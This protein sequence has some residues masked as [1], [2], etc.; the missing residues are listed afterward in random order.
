MIEYRVSFR[1]ARAL[2]E[3]AVKGG[4]A[5]TIYTEF[6]KINFLFESSRE[7]RS[8]VSNPIF[9]LWKKKQILTSILEEIECSAFTTTF[10]LFVVDKRRG[11]LIE[12]IIYQFGV[13]FNQMKNNLPVQIN[14]AVELNDMLKNEISSRLADWTKKTIQPNYSVKPELKGGFSVQIDDW[15]YDATLKNQLEVLHRKL[16]LD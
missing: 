7:L 11:M 1:Y 2:L 10:L 5:D 8:M 15:V 14:S 13:L 3:L 4:I 16:A 9:Q 12:S 6:Q